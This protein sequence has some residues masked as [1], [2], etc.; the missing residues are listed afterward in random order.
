[1]AAQ[2]WP[3]LLAPS[4]AQTWPLLLDDGSAKGYGTTVSSA[5]DSGVSVAGDVVLYDITVD[6]LAEGATR[7]FYAPVDLSQVTAPLDLEYVLAPLDLSQV[8][9]PLDVTNTLAPLD[10]ET[11]VS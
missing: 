6:V 1:M 5:Y 8:T 9:A 7:P 2:T 3:L 11:E 4:S 10:M